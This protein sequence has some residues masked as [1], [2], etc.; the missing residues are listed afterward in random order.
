MSHHCSRKET[1][2]QVKPAC[3]NSDVS[4]VQLRPMLST[5][6]DAKARALEYAE[7]YKCEWNV[8]RVEYVGSATIPPVAIWRDGK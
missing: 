5:L 4:Y 8:Y 2:Y 3:F 6:E 7:R 1:Y